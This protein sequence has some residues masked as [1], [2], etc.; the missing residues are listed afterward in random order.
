MIKI[1]NTISVAKKNVQSGGS[2]TDYLYA[3]TLSKDA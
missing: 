1:I 2:K 3:P